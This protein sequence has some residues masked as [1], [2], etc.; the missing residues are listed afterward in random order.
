MWKRISERLVLRGKEVWR[1]A[2]A[3]ELMRNRCRKNTA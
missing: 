3:K 2:K 1:K